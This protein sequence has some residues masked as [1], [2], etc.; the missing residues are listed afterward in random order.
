MADEEVVRTHGGVAGDLGHQRAVHVEHDRAAHLVGDG[1]H[2]VVDER[3]TVSGHGTVAAGLGRPLELQIVVGVA[4]EQGEI[5]VLGVHEGVVGITQGGE[6]TEED[7]HGEGLAVDQIHDGLGEVVLATLGHETLVGEV[8]LIVLVDGQVVV[9]YGILPYGG[10]GGI[11]L[12]LVVGHETVGDDGGG[13]PL[14]GGG[15]DHAGEQRG[16]Q[17]EGGQ[18]SGKNAL[19]FHG[20]LLL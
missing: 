15:K 12:A 10:I 3:Q 5:V 17:H 2:A 6:V 7:L 9:T 18:Q 1:D 16:G 14:G 20:L 8:V 13:L 11:A 4:A 19:G